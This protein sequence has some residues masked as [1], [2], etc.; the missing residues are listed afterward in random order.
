M[1]TKP[2]TRQSQYVC[3]RIG[4]EVMAIVFCHVRGGHLEYFNFPK[5]ARVA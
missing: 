2:V 4:N 3:G 5:G 1:M